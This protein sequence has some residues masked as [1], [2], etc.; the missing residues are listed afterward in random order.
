MTLTGVDLR[1]A[2]LRGANLRGVAILKEGFGAT[3]SL[4]ETD[5]R[6]ARLTG[7]R[8]DRC[9]RWPRGFDPV[10]AGAVLVR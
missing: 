8:Y 10:K 9:T 1:G 7:A 3:D 5:L 4:G 2:D 6:H